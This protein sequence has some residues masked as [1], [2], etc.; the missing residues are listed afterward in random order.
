MTCTNIQQT[1]TYILQYT[2]LILT[3]LRWFST[4]ST[5]TIACINNVTFPNKLILNTGGGGGGGSISTGGEEEEEWG[6]YQYMYVMCISLTNC[7][8]ASLA[9]LGFS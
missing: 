1:I 5:W 3:V 9:R 2:H 8:C 6:E 4:V 7:S